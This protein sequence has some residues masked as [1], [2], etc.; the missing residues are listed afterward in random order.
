MRD[1]PRGYS[2]SRK[3][4]VPSMNVRTA[5]RE[6]RMQVMGVPRRKGARKR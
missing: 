5:E 6:R 4:S 3:S 2:N 1:R